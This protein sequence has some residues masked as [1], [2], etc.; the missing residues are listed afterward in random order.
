MYRYIRW[1][2]SI[3]GGTPK[4]CACVL[5][6]N[7][8]THTHHTDRLYRRISVT[9]TYIHTGTPSICAVEFTNTHAH[10]QLNWAK[11]NG[12]KSERESDSEEEKMCTR[13]HFGNSS[14]FTSVSVL[15]FL[16]VLDFDLVLFLYNFRLSL[17]L[18]LSAVLLVRAP[19]VSMPNYVRQHS[20]LIYSSKNALWFDAWLR[21]M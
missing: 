3:G 14:F 10:W 11:P 8:N 18:C 12:R 19:F 7:R 16:R 17:A 5:K 21:Y 20:K 4:Y 1:L 6:R 2:Y 9:Q 15:L 13:N